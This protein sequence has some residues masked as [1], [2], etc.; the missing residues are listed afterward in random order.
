MPGSAIV[1]QQF[2]VNRISHKLAVFVERKLLE[3]GDP[4]RFEGDA[5]AMAQI[6][7]KQFQAVD[8][9]QFQKSLLW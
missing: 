1:G 9:F 6:K 8:L 7:R 2:Y 4:F 3:S 5:V